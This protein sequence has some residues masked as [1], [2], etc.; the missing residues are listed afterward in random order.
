[1]TQG[2]ACT[3]MTLWNTAPPPLT[4]RNQTEDSESWG[5]VGAIWMV[6]YWVVLPYWLLVIAEE[7]SAKVN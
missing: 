1:M 5:V 7:F 3:W 2:Q 4:T 6:G